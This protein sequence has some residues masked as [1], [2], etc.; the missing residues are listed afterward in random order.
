[1]AQTT[2]VFIYLPGRVHPTVAG[3]FDW[4]SGVSPHVGEFVYAESYLAN[5]A[6][7]PLDPIALPLRAQVFATTLSSGF[8]GVFRDAI[9]DDWGRHVALKLFGDSYQT[10]FDYLWLHTA[11]RI[12]ALAFG[13]S[14]HGP[15][16]EKPLLEWQQL[17]Q[18][19]LLDA[20][21]HIDRDIPL[22]AAEEEAVLAFGAGTSAGGARPKLSVLKN[23]DVWLAKLNRQSDRF[24]V[25][26]VE[27]AMLDLAAACGI[28]VPEHG[29]EHVHGQDVLLVRRFDRAVSPEG[30]LRHRMVSAATV[31]QADEAAARYFYTGSYPRLARELSRWTL[32]GDQDRRQL[33][34]RIAFHSLASV[35]DDHDRNHALIAVNA[36]FR[37]SPA[38]DLVPQPGN[39]QRRYLALAIGDFGALAARQNMLSSIDAFGLSPREANGIIDEVQEVVRANWRKSCAGWGVGETDVARIEG[40]FDPPFFE[41]ELPPNAVM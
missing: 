37:L 4:E 11:D 24:N 29:V 2:Y 14:T 35:T 19:V 38:F 28:S 34:R 32:T 30:I 27:C 36:H 41:S 6:S 31:F 18:S 10:D 15:V 25:V 1:M 9:P 8:F 12:G 22:T 23:G 7:V 33:F 5:D 39:T 26:R 21:Q 3:R 17:E 40:C 16:E 20:I 13:Q